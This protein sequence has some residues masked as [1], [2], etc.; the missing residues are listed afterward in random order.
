MSS[1]GKTVQGTGK[2][3]KIPLYPPFSKGEVIKGG[4]QMKK[5]GRP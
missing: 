3:K 4:V 2:M 1:S 5:P